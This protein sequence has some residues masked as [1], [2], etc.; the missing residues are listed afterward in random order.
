MA[1]PAW[2]VAV[3]AIA[4]RTSLAAP[5]SAGSVRWLSGESPQRLAARLRHLLPPA[6]ASAAQRVVRYPPFWRLARDDPVVYDDG[7]TRA[8]RTDRPDPGAAS[9]MRLTAGTKV[10]Q[11]LWCL[12]GASARHRW[13]VGTCRPDRPGGPTRRI[14]DQPCAGG[15]SAVGVGASDA[16]RALSSR[17]SPPL[18]PCNRR[19]VGGQ[20]TIASQAAAQQ[21]RPPGHVSAVSDPSLHVLGLRRSTDATTRRTGR[22]HCAYRE[23]VPAGP[24]ARKDAGVALATKCE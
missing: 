14:G 6:P 13:P 7:R 18:Q 1:H 5:A 2:L 9:A 24:K 8:P 4:P 22:Q 3:A 19:S 12:C 10:L 23:A 15:S 21:R 17:C 11:P 16:A 20:N